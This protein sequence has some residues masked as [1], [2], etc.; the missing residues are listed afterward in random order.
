MRLLIVEDEYRLADMIR[1]WLVREDYEADIATDG[2][3]GYHMAM[4]GI[5]D[6]IILDVMLPE[7]DGFELLRKI[8]KQHNQAQV[9]M[10]TA[11]SGLEDKIQ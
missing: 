11:K 3:E 5:Y 8:R 6:V 1:D 7:M 9:L 10:L 4:L 2:A